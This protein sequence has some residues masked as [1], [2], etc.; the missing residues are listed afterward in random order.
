MP[1]ASDTRMQKSSI[2]ASVLVGSVALLAVLF[3]ALAH[4][5]HAPDTIE[6]ASTPSAAATR[7]RAPSA[8]ATREDATAAAATREHARGAAATR[9]RV[10]DADASSDDPAARHAAH[11][12][13]PDAAPSRESS[14]GAVRASTEDAVDEPPADGFA[15]LRGRV[16]APDGSPLGAA[17][18]ILYASVGGE[19]VRPPLASAIADRNGEFRVE[20]P[21]GELILLVCAAH[22]EPATRVL[23]S[24]RSE[25]VE[26]GSVRLASGESIH[27]HVLADKSPLARAEIAAVLD[28]ALD[29]FATE[30]GF[31]KWIHQ[32]FAWSFAIADS[33]A[34]GSFSISGLAPETYRVRISS[35]RGRPAVLGFTSSASRTTRAPA[36]DVDFSLDTATQSV[37]FRFAGAPVRGVEAQLEADGAHINATSDADGMSTFRTTPRLEGTL[38]AHAP[39]YKL[40]RVPLTAP[41]PSEERAQ[42]VELEVDHPPAT[43]LFDL[44]PPDGV[45]GARV[46]R[47]RFVFHEPGADVSR[48]NR[49]SLVV[50]VDL[51]SPQRT[52]APRNVGPRDE[53]EIPGVSPGVYR[54]VVQAGEVLGYASTPLGNVPYCEY[55][56]AEIPIS[57]PATGEVHPS[58]ALVARSTLAIAAHDRTGRGLP[59]RAKLFDAR[60]AALELSL[61]VR[62]NGISQSLT[63][64]DETGYTS[65]RSTLCSGPAEI[66]LSCNG[67]KTQ[68]TR[69][70]FE[71]QRALPIDV[72]LESE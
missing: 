14:R 26:L 44:V 65:V 28:S 25:T 39:G 46:Q 55:C 63:S 27:G 50:E 59:A 69:V 35:L 48:E 21:T 6:I 70:T 45:G 17:H 23:R 31:V 66:E 49:P 33:G 32:R 38:T 64:L 18:A 4:S 16:E 58:V 13:V 61:A 60:G 30:A 54:V 56:D 37:A 19:P 3:F 11:L 67:Y 62:R 43:I 7:E 1:R 24:T 52:R 68:R 20:G 10:S 29:T 8:A 57:V 9:E 34:D 12:D 72:T 47:A 51:K 5:P 42:T 36:D 53:F 41:G 22:L 15:R 40:V 71:G 2:V